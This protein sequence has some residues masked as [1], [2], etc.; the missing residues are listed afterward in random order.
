MLLGASLS[1]RQPSTDNKPN[2]VESSTTTKTAPTLLVFAKNITPDWT[3]M[4]KLEPLQL[5]L[6]AQQDNSS[7]N[8]TE[9]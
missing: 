3:D 5:V 7:N 6:Q 9:N 2:F 8:I 4:A 1:H